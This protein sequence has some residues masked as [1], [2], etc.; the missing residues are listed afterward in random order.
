M[1]HGRGKKRILLF[2][3]QTADGNG[4]ERKLDYPGDGAGHF[5]IVSG[6]LGGG[7]IQLQ[8]KAIDGSWVNILN[9]VISE[10]TCTFLESTHSQRIIRAVLS[11][12]SG[13]NV[14]VEVI[15]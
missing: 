6:N 4:D 5:I 8:I 13:A 3:G 2:Q 15:S 12:S 11:G 1:A 9:G 14:N 10:L 7:S